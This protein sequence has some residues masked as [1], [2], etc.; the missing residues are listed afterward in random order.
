VAR[1]LVGVLCVCGVVVAAQASVPRA[2]NI[3]A[4][5]VERVDPAADYFP[6]KVAIEDAG[7]FSV[8]Y[9][10]SYKVVTIKEVY[11]GAPVND[12]CSRSATAAMPW[13]TEPAFAPRWPR[14][15]WSARAT[16]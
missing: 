15:C 16:P 1:G 10:K 9:R 4:G 6:D 12:T 2:T 7:T 13:S 3:T 14:P 11:A 5:C 8:E